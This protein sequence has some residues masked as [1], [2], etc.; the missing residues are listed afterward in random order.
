[1]FHAIC[2]GKKYFRPIR[3]QNCAQSYMIH[4]QAMKSPGNPWHAEMV[5]THKQKKCSQRNIG[6]KKNYLNS[7]EIAILLNYDHIKTSR[8]AVVIEERYEY[9]PCMEMIHHTKQPLHDSI[10]ISAE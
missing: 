10:K 3:S 6:V 9:V 1:M 7:T 4:L 5:H 8:V 2:W